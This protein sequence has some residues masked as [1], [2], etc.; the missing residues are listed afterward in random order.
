M[1]DKI[2][3]KSALIT[4]FKFKSK[5]YKYKGTEHASSM[6]ASWICKAQE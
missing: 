5:E 6:Y 3:V 4:D 1:L 2:V